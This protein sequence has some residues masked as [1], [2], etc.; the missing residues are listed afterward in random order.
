MP[1]WENHGSCQDISDV[2]P[3]DPISALSPTS[4]EGGNMRASNEDAL[5]APGSQ[6]VDVMEDAG[7]YF[8]NDPTI[9]VSNDTPIEPGTDGKPQASKSADGIHNPGAPGW[10]RTGG[11][12]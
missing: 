11:G 1:E 8:T 4:Q 10:H 9:E 5:T 6:P 3:K 12:G 2:T 7:R